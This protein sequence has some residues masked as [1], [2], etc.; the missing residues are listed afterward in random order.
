MPDDASIV[1][2]RGGRELVRQAKSG[3]QQQF[4]DHAAYLNYLRGRNYVQA[5]NTSP[6]HTPPPPPPPPVITS[7][8]PRNTSLIVNFTQAL[9]APSIVNYMYSTDN[10]VTFATL[11]PIS[12]TSPLVITALST[13]STTPLTN[14]DTYSVVIKAIT[15]TRESLQ[16]N[17]ETGTPNYTIQTFTTV[18]TSTYTIPA[19]VYNI[20]YLVVAGGGGGGLSGGGVGNGG[21]GGGGTVRSGSLTVIPNTQYEIQVGA[22]GR[23]AFGNDLESGVST[24]GQNSR[25]DTIISL[26]G[27]RGYDAYEVDG[28]VSVGG[29]AAVAPSIA[30]GGGNGDQGGGRGSGG[31]GGAGGNGGNGGIGISGTKGAGIISSITNM[32]VMYGEGGLGPYSLANVDGIP[33][34]PNTGNGGDG[35]SRNEAYGDTILGG[36]GGSGI[37]ILK[38]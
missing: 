3:K 21:G 26:G 23:G 14:G 12:T 6:R 18:G 2:S 24:P 1:A 34:A 7:V 10:G 11:S 15:D 36:N 16:S 28:G 33:G 25:F 20:E 30:S 29:N 13:D 8:V 4:P 22:G 5:R 37:V 17:M 35:G 38:Y 32:E 31:G 9:A 19:N 27:G